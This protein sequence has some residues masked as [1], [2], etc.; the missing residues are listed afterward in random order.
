MNENL[1]LLNSHA[2][3][4]TFSGKDISDKDEL[5]IISTSQHSSTSSNRQA[6]SIIGIRDKQKKKKLAE[7]AGNQQHIIDSSLFLV[8]CADLFRLERINKQKK[9]ETHSGYTELFIIATVDAA[10]VAERALITAQA[11][12]IG[13][14]M[15]GG[16]R[17]NPSKVDD[18]LQLPNLVYPVMGMSLGFPLKKPKVKPRLHINAIYHREEYS[19]VYY[20]KY[21]DEYDT[22]IDKLG[23]LKGREVF[24]EKYPTFKG[25]YSWSEHTARRH[26]EIVRP[27]MKSYLE[28]KR[29]LKK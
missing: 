13:G 9:Y 28:N 18:L 23:Y 24:T 1:K 10:L 12:G 11:L 21:I 2:S 19:D 14:V 7:L 6:Y 8:F 29:F 26:A 17:N 27:H 15:V 5:T 22:V 20:A 25:L 4:R 3:V 16:I